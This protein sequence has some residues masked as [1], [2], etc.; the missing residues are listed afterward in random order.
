VTCDTAPPYFALNEMEVA[1][2]RT[3]AKL[4]PPLRSEDDRLAIVEGLKSGIIDA[5]ASDHTPQDE[6][7]KRLP[8]AQAACGG[9]GLE[10]LLPVT[11]SLAH[12]GEMGILD[13]L[14][15]VTSAPADL[16]NLPA[17][18]LQKGAP[19]DLTIFD[20]ERGWQVTAAALQSK[21]KNSPFDERPVQGRVLRTVIDGRSVYEDG[22]A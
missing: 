16:M 11:L 20:P 5:V 14:K 4:S 17:G 15:L 22:G 7:S 10:T 6:E 12:N 3:F 21:S 19:A 8:F 13:A 18:R 1:D 9:V 2:Y